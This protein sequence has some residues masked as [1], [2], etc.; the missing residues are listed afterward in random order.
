MNLEFFKLVIVDFRSYR[1]KHELDIRELGNGLVFLRGRNESEPALESNNVGKS[2]LLG[3]LSW[4]LYG[5]TP[6]GLRSTDVPT[7]NDSKRSRVK[8]WVRAGDKLH[9]IQR[10]A[11]PNSLEIDGQASSQEAIDKLLRLDCDLFHHTILLGQGQPLFFDLTAGDAMSLFTSTLKLERWDDRSKLAGQKTSALEHDCLTIEYDIQAIGVTDSEFKTLAVDLKRKSQEWQEEN[12]RLRE[13][14]EKRLLDL[15]AKYDQ[16]KVRHDKANLDYDSAQTEL[17]A[18]RSKVKSM[19]N[20]LL[21]AQRLYDSAFNADQSLKARLSTLKSDLTEA[22]GKRCPVCNQA[23][24]KE[25]LRAHRDEIR[26]KIKEIETQIKPAR[27][28]KTAKALDLLSAGLKNLQ[29]AEPSLVEKSDA[30]QATMNLLQP[31]LT[32]LAGEMRHLRERKK[33]LEGS[34]DP[35]REQLSELRRKLTKLASEVKDHEKR[36]KNLKALTERTRFWVKGFKDVRL[37]IT[38][39][40]LKELELTTNAILEDV[41]LSAWRV[42]YE[43]ESE[44]K[45]GKI[46][47]GLD[48]VIESPENKKAVRWAAWGGGVAQRLRLVGA[49]ALSEV[50]LHRAGVSSNLL[51]MDEPTRSLSRAGIDDL[52]ELLSDLAKRSRKTVLFV[53]HHAVPSSRFSTVLT[54]IR[55]NTG[56]RIAL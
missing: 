37:Y 52:V 23:V 34:A 11:N 22:G 47:S 15:G 27:I 5:R 1:G 21:V 42:R 26:A 18:I 53:D 28:T 17:R 9:T 43:V 24:D 36:L 16:F 6:E 41:G 20:E 32:N 12:E 45:T 4:C 40:V 51:I 30:A 39:E 54:V 55:D 50:L 13:S 25:T 19:T 31:E 44:T 10:T 2:T 38:E 46:K 14:G 3:A 35:Y 33:E 8:L 7:W 48:I 56:S 49:I 29:K